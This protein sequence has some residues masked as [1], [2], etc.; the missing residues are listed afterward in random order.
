VTD[1]RSHT[2]RG[3]WPLPHPSWRNTAWLRRHPWFE[4]DL[5]PDLRRAIRN[6][7]ETAP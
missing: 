6:L 5:L 2:A 7:M 1:W 3:I 4:T